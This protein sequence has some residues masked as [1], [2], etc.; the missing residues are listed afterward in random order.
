MEKTDISTIP[1][2]MKTLQFKLNPFRLIIGKIRGLIKKSGYWK[3]GGPLAFTSSPTPLKMDE[4][5]V[6]VKTVSCG[7]C[8][9]DV[10]EITMNGA[11]N[12][13]LR[14]LMSFPQ[15]LGHEVVGVIEKIGESVSELKKG[16]W[17]AINPWFSCQS[18][19]RKP[20]CP[21]CQQGDFTHCQNFTKGYL[22]KGMGL[23]TIKHFGGFAPYVTV[24][25]SQ[26]FIIPKNMTFKQAVLINP[27]S[28]A[29]HTCLLLNPK[30]TDTILVYGLGVIGL[31]TVMCLKKIFQIDKVIAIGKYEHQNEMA[32]KLGASKV[33]TSSGNTLI[34][35]ITS[36]INA[37]LYKPDNGYFWTIDGVDSIIDT[38]GSAE[39]RETAMRIIAAQGKIII[40]GISK[41]KRYENKLHRFKELE[42]I[43]SNSFGIEKFRGEK[44]HAF[45]Y[46]MDFVSEGLI[47]PSIFVTHKFLLKDYKE[48]LKKITKKK[49]SKAIKVV[50]VF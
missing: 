6:L 37:E 19:R 36:Y 9:S 23:G 25:E 11:F 43:G 20:I 28:V 16:D 46:F 45:E 22:P 5:W 44:K 34:E 18:R 26:C 33:F 38:I 29:F 21:R 15:I 32:I 40:T 27:F 14:S 12:N 8:G 30:K 1:K 47:D 3:F 35:E 50:F 39:T 2:R 48:A 7:I 24:H 4:D 42:I 41:P 49:D 10:K 17:V 31:C 13:P